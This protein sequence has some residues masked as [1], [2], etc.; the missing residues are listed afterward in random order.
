MRR[1]NASSA[2]EG[3]DGSPKGAVIASPRTMRLAPIIA[4]IVGSD[5]TNTVGMP[6]RSISFASVDP[7]RVPVP[8][9]PESR[10]A[11]TFASWSSWAISWPNLVEAATVVPFPVV[12]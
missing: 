3:S 5:V 2:S 11:P 6:A 9:V 7:Q 1:R 10:T 8:Q 12:V 4:A